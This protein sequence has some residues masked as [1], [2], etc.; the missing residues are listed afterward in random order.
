M[1]QEPEALA[2]LL[3]ST[4]SSQNIDK[5]KTPDVVKGQDRRL[6]INV[7]LNASIEGCQEGGSLLNTRQHPA[8]L[9][10]A[11]EARQF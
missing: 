3:V 7:G 1:K 2:K 5:D 11:Y 4:T 8:G 9:E 10:R 6:D